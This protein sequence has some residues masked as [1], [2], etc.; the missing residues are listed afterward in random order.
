[1]SNRVS[2]QTVPLDLAE[3]SH[4]TGLVVRAVDLES[5]N[6]LFG[7]IEKYVS[8]KRTET[9]ECLKPALNETRA[10]VGAEPIYRHK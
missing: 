7:E 2:K 1:M 10:S 3:L 4:K 9:F 8:D 5:V 6:R